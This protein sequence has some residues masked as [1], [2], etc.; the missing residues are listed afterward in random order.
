MSGNKISGVLGSVKHFFGDGA[1]F[2]GANEGNARVYN[3]T[4][5]VKRNTQGYAGAIASNV[6]NVMASYSGINEVRNSLN[7]Y[8]LQGLL[9]EDLG[10]NGFVISDYDELT[11]VPHQTY[12]TG[13]VN[14]T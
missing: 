8:Y 3:S 13:F 6:G 12:P 11:R 1:T 14:M 4:T 9:R 5:F 7:S 10:F 2:Y